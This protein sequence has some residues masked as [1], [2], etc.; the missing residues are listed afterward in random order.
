[1]SPAPGQEIYWMHTG[2]TNDDGFSRGHI[3]T[4][5]ENIVIR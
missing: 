3:L 1:M 2:R 5:D 4:R